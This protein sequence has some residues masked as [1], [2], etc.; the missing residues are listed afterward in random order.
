MD[1]PELATELV[2]N[3][4]RAMHVRH[5]MSIPEIGTMFQT[6]NG[7]A[8]VVTTGHITMGGLANM[9]NQTDAKG[10]RDF[11]AL[12]MQVRKLDG[13]TDD[14]QVCTILTNVVTL[15]MVQAR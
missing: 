4:F 14:L 11:I 10:F 9:L 12:F 2:E 15:M 13:V 8:S 1:I 7:F 6:Y 5:D 3:Y